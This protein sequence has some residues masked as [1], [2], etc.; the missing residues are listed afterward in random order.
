VLIVDDIVTTGGS[1]NDMVA[2]VETAGG[3]VVG[4]GVLGDR[5]G[6]RLDLAAPFFACLT[7]DFP[8]YP[9][10]EC[11]LCAAGI[12]LSPAR[13]SGTPFLPLSASARGREKGA[14]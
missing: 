12:P 1:V 6:G 5:T 14:R 2:C 8:S 13:G 11:P 10:A 3:S 7:V 9:A 4:V